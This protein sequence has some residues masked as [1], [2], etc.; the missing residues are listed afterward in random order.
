M[1][2]GIGIYSMLAGAV[3]ERRKEFGIRLALGASARG[4]I[5]LV[6]RS[7]VVI[8]AVGLGLGLAGVVAL[9][10]LLESRLYGVSRF[11]PLS[12]MLAA[13]AIVALS[14]IASVL[15]AIRAARIDPVRS[16]RVE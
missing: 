7:S 11:D 5:G 13:V 12:M 2:A 1:L 8:A 4:V 14:V 6:M 15:P 16:L 9:G 10:R 3:A